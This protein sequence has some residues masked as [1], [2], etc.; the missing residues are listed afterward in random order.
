MGRR[1]DFLAGVRSAIVTK[2]KNPQWSPAKL[3]E[4]D[5]GA[6]QAMFDPLC[7]KSECP[8]LVLQETNG[9]SRL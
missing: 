3:S 6:V 4:V 7:V 1:P 2:D 8:E 5:E 9:Q